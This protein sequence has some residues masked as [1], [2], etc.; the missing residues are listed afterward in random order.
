MPSLLSNGRRFPLKAGIN[1]LGRDQVCDIFVPDPHISRKHLSLDVVGDGTL[2]VI[3]L[4]ST[5][6]MVVNSKR[7]PSAILS[8]GDSFIVGQTTFTVTE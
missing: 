2:T 7:V 1:L 3:D 4:G 5:N 6:G 8:I